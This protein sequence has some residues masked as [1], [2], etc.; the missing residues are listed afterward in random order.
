MHSYVTTEK[1][2]AHF[3]KK[4]KGESFCLYHSSYN[5]K[6]IIGSTFQAFPMAG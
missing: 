1:V 2:K 5:T 4:R 6:T 3:K